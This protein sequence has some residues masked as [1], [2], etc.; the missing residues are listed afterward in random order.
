[1]LDAKEKTNTRNMKLNTMEKCQSRKKNARQRKNLV[2][3]GS[4]T[5]LVLL[6]CTMHTIYNTR[7]TEL[8]NSLRHFGRAQKMP[9]TC[10]QISAALY[11][12]FRDDII[13]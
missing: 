12:H 6:K 10:V 3:G 9:N 8:E 5:V 2:E 13:N 7:I 11:T 1:M 4:G